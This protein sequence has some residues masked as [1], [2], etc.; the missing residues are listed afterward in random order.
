MEELYHI[1]I[2]DTDSLVYGCTT[3]VAAIII[4]ELIKDSKFIDYPN[5]IR[6]NPNIPWKSRGNGAV[7]LRF[8]SKK[9]EYELMD[10]ILKYIEEYR[11]KKDE[12]NQPG[13]VILKGNVPTN[14]KEFGKKAL[15]DVITLDE[16]I[17][18]LRKNNIIYHGIKEGRGLIGALA[19]IGNTL[20]NDHTFELIVYR[21]EYS[22]KREVD[23]E[24]VIEFD[25][26]TFPF[27][28][29]NI[30]YESGRLLIT[31]HGT[32]PIL[33]GVRGEDPEVLKKALKIIKFKGADRWV[34][35]RTNQGTDAHFFEFKKIKSLK[36]YQVAI[37]KGVVNKKPVFIEGGHVI[38][39]IADETG[40]ID[41]AC[42][43]P[44]GNL[45]MIAMELMPGDK[46]IVYGGVR[47]L[48]N[49]KITINL[50]KLE[51]L[52]L[53]NEQYVNPICPKCKKSMKSEGKNKGYQCKKCK[54]K[55]KERI[56]IKI[57]RKIKEG[58]YLPPP[59]S[60]RHLTKPLQ[61]YGM[62]K[63]EW[64]GIVMEFFGKL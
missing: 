27:T 15:N 38:F 21:K 11:D 57:E 40:E 37:I 39:S 34:I 3:Y 54:I 47:L 58:I 24:S 44:S 31:P 13:V 64:N 60:M 49:N 30:D 12:K 22:K 5:L 46:L 6:L 4:E 42:Y 33:F 16:T 29:N 26:Q 9:D 23:M 20:D 8:Y 51:I 53:I 63:K 56:K 17:L 28:F 61:R 55:I 25:R 52:E 36:P 62:E 19:A 35:Y 1:G 41:V 2:D 50:E 48:D 7:C 14:I 43:E 59:R 45:R 10:L 32:D 18:L